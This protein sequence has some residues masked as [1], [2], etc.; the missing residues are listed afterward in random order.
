MELDSLKHVWAAHGAALARSVAINERLLRETLL[1]K[2]RSSLAPFVVGRVLEIVLGAV[3]V[4]LIGS[5]LAAHATEPRYLVAGG[6]SLAFAVGV[7]AHAVALLV[8]S[9]RLAYD[10]P[11]TAI[12]RAVEHA[13]WLE[14]RATKWAL[15]GGVVVW[16]PILLVGYE[17]LTGVAVLARVDLAWLIANLGFGLVVLVL[18]QSWSKR[19]AERTDL[20]PFAR[21]LVD[22]ASGRPLRVAARHLAELARFERDEPPTA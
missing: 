12:Q 18:G 22:A 15:L 13:R 1:D 7:T 19:H 11:V 5:V 2:V 17:A 9:T 8:A 14:Y 10:Q 3:A 6:A 16:L 21:R 4:L 20:G